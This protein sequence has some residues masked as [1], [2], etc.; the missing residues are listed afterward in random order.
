VKSKL[1]HIT[2]QG[3]LGTHWASTIKLLP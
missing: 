1:F 2:L 3:V